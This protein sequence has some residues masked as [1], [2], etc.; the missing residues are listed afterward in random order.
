MVSC[1]ASYSIKQHSTNI[2]DNKAA[3]LLLS[4]NNCSMVTT[5]LRHLWAGTEQESQEKN[6]CVQMREREAHLLQMQKYEFL[7]FLLVC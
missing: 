1:V 2:A 4:P 7:T 6:L 5:S 3:I